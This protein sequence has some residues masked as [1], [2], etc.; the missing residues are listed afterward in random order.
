MTS[1]REY[2]FSAASQADWIHM[3]LARD[4]AEKIL[5]AKNLLLLGCELEQRFDILLENYAALEE[6]VLVLALRNAIFADDT[7][8][9]FS[10]ARHHMNRH[11]NNFLSSAK[12]Y[13]DQTAHALHAF[14]KRLNPV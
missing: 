2:I 3:E 11:L 9:R 5:Q 8:K 14:W 13:L 6:Y 7:P 10:K 4:D 12:L 1:D